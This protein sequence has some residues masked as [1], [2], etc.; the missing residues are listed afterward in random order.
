MPD[1]VVEQDITDLVE[2]RDTALEYTL[3]LIYR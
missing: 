3:E 2:G 1:H